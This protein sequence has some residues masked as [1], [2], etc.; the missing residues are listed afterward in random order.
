MN[1]NTHMH[2]QI[3]LITIQFFKELILGIS[4]SMMG[5]GESRGTF[6]GYTSL[7]GCWKIGIFFCVWLSELFVSLI[8]FFRAK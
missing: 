8:S 2:T 5:D 1:C 4:E 6:H 3:I 7:S